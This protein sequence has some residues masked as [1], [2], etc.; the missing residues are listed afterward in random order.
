MSIVSTDFGDSGHDYD[1]MKKR[2]V[3]VIPF[4]IETADL[5]AYTPPREILSLIGITRSEEGGIDE[6]RLKQWYINRFQSIIGKNI[7]FLVENTTIK[8]QERDSFGYW[9]FRFNPQNPII[10]DYSY[11]GY[12]LTFECIRKQGRLKV[13]RVSFDTISSRP[14]ETEGIIEGNVYIARD[15]CDPHSGSYLSQDDFTWLLRLPQRKKT[16]IKRLEAWNEYLEEHLKVIQNK[17]GWVAYKDLRRINRTQAVIE[18]SSEDYS[19]NADKA[20]FPEDEVQLLLHEIPKDHHWRPGEDDEEPI[21]FGSISKDSRIKGL[22]QEEKRKGKKNSEMVSITIDLIDKWIFSEPDT[23]ND[24]GKQN[25]IRQDPLERLPS[26]G[27][28][29]NSVFN[30]ELPL[31]LQQKAVSRLMDKNAANPRLEDFVFDVHEARTPF[32]DDSIDLNTLVERKLNKNQ[33][34]AVNTAL[35]APDICLI[36]G[37]PG[38]GKTTV[39]AELCNQVTLRGGKVLISSQ[40]N[41]AVDNA[42]SRLA[43]VKHIRP[44]RLGFRTTEEGHD[45]LADNVVHHWFQGVK[46]KLHENLEEQKEIKQDLRKFEDAI[47]TMKTLHAQYQDAG[48]EC[49]RLQEKADRIRHDMESIISER[50]E[51]KGRLNDTAR[52]IGV[53]DGIL[54]EGLIKPSCVPLF[55][56]QYP[57]ISGP[58][59]KKIATL[60]P[61]HECPGAGEVSQFLDLYSNLYL[62]NSNRKKSITRLSRLLE[63]VIQRNVETEQKEAALLQKRDTIQSEMLNVTTEEDMGALSH[64]LLLVNKEIKALN[65]GGKKQLAVEWR[66]QLTGFDTVKDYYIRC[67]PYLGIQSEDTKYLLS[68]LSAS[69][70]PDI[71]YK[72]VIQRLLDFTQGIYDDLFGADETILCTIRKIR[73]DLLSEKKSFDYKDL[74]LQRRLDEQEKSHQ[75]VEHSLNDELKRKEHCRDQISQ[76]YQRMQQYRGKYNLGV[77][78]DGNIAETKGEDLLGARFTQFIADRMADLNHLQDRFSSVL[79]KAPRWH[80]LQTEWVKKIEKS[81][82]SDYEAIKDTYVSFAN[83]VGATCTETGKF[84]FWNGRVFDLVIIDEVSKATPPELLMPMLLGKQ[85]VL[86]GDHHQLP[87]IFR[88]R[89][90][91]LTFSEA[92]DEDDVKKRL[93]KFENLVTSSYFEEM[94]IKADNSLKSRLT[95]QYRMHP[96]IMNLINQFYPPNYQLTCGI[97][98]PDAARQHPF[99]LAGKNGDLTPKNAH[100]VWIDTSQRLVKEGL[101]DNFEGKEEGKYSS[102]YNAYEVDVTSTI[103]CSLNEQCTDS[104]LKYKDIAVISFYAGQVR[105]LKA[106]RNSLMQSGRLNNLR[107]RVG[108][109]DEFQGMERP[110]VIVSLVSA[111]EKMNGSRRPTSFVKEFRR[112]NVAFSRAQSL[113]AVVGAAEVFHDVP[114]TVHY[115]G[116]EEK[117]FP[118]RFMLNAAKDGIQG[119]SYVRGYELNGISN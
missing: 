86:V 14:Y 95:E 117:K 100:A 62:I 9:R 107:V 16:L 77:S 49:G 53:M 61:E 17:I 12:S 59:Q 51:N 98:E 69:L 78:E 76:L 81:S 44:I 5:K 43:N 35:N 93:K 105:K 118:Y 39:I 80:A 37:P 88:L 92:D 6:E 68:D 3:N 84:R 113:L 52:N 34:D 50:E 30:D 60:F 33:I 31:K 18:I 87:P 22:F 101:I 110:V 19:D 41:L 114:V 20:F 96:T 102:R 72:S 24:L 91:E 75:S 74:A 90:D 23:P 70:T 55:L 73:E 115:D 116:T 56:R 89:Q 11:N 38:T 46:E 82:Q 32:R 57:E 21:R 10:D 111:P 54:A 2:R 25:S 104:D 63:I 26:S 40:S 42:L 66:D 45:F 119:S 13:L 108:T 47:Q 83:V 28:L 1:G 58:L 8:D 67:M 29:V 64:D 4:L 27:L 106:M 15:V 65:D 103:L 112:I 99:A 79:E 48:V 97:A 7:S 71:R 109:V 85:V 36:Q 94:F